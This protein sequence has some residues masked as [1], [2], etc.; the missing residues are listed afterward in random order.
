MEYSVR[1][2]ILLYPW[3]IVRANVIN[4]IK[5]LMEHSL[6]PAIKQIPNYSRFTVTTTTDY[7]ERE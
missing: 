1:M 7:A 6:V 4:E 3:V 2:D 5:L